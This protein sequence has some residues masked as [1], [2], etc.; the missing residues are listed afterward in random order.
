MTAELDAGAAQVS[1]GS[2][3]SKRT[4]APVAAD[5]R[6]ACNSTTSLSASAASMFEIVIT[7]LKNCLGFKVL[8]RTERS[9]WL[10]QP[11]AH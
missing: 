9:I 4:P 2:S 5:M 3:G 11:G 1:A 10:R 7:M 6:T 8:R